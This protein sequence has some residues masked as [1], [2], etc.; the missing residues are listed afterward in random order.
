MTRKYRV[1]QW[2]TGHVGKHSLRAI[3]RHPEMELV[4]VWVSSA[5]KEGKDAGELCGIEPTGVKA[6][7]NARDLLELDADC[8]CYTAAT[9]FRPNEAVEDMCR[10]LASGKNVV[11]SSFVPL[12][13]PWQVVPQYAQALEEACQQGGATFYCSGIDPGFSPDALPIVLSSLSER[14]ESIRAQEIFDY[15]SYDQ[16]ETLFEVMGF[17]K[18]PGT[19]VPLLLPGSLSLAWGPS[20]RMVADALEVELDEVREWHEVAVAEESFEISCGRI[21][22]GTVAGIHFEVSGIVGGKP[23]IVVEH[24]TRLRDDIAPDWPRG[25]GP[26]TYRV[27]I[28]GMPSM[29]CTLEIG[30]RSPDHNI[31]GCVGT[32]MR[33]VNA[34]PAVCAAEPGLK[35]WLDLPLVAGRFALRG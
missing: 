21:E 5:E 3:A 11:T 13:Y 28:E 4:G 18:P 33:L 30:F 1:I 14:I 24:V 7:T 2:A 12:I 15:A 16:P 22:K 32:A 23:V 34:I 35:S 27:T 9:D 31:D 6:T 20:V 8:V 19:S 10:I 25:V 17:G 26:G 29:R